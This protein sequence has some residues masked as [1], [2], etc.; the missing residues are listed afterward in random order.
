MD[1]RLP[2]EG[3]LKLTQSS[4]KRDNMTKDANLLLDKEE[5]AAGGRGVGGGGG[6]IV[7]S[8]DGKLKGKVCFKILNGKL[9]IV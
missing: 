9:F 3:S 8:S 5:G 4:A 1:L 7:R 2:C 6:D